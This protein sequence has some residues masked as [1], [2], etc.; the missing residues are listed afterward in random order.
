M[1]G[2][3]PGLEKMT[4]F[5]SADRLSSAGVEAAGG[6]VFWGEISPCEHLV[7][8]YNDDSAFMDALEGFVTGG[9][10]AGDGL[11]LIGTPEHLAALAHRLDSHGVDVADAIARDQYIALDAEETLAKFM[12][13][14]GS[15][16]WPDQTRFEKVV[17]ELLAR[18]STGP[19]GRPGGRRVRAFGEMV[20]LLWKQGHTGA[21][22]R[23]ENLWHEFCQ[24]KAFCLFCA[25]PRAFFTQN[26]EESMQQICDAHS[27]VVR[28]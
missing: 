24:K 17:D 11:I 22:V 4:T 19:D 20:A 6:P 18:A 15:M 23:L 5:G 27:K 21:T 14:L 2:K 28:G 3:T 1:L 7:Q 12:G 13:T 25:Y 8:I 26:A 16:Q 9:L 10:R